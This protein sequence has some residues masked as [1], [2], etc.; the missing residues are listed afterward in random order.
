MLQF[1]SQLDDKESLLRLTGGFWSDT[2]QGQELLGTAL[3]ARASLTKQTFE[4]LQEAIDCRSRLDIPLYRKEYWRAVVLKKSV[5]E[6]FPNLYGENVNYGEGAV[7]G[8]RSASL[9]FVYP[10][11]A[12]LDDCR[13]I[14]NRLTEAS[15]NLISGL[16]F[17]IDKNYKLLRLKENPFNNPGFQKQTFEDGEEEVTLWFYKPSIDREYVYQHFGYVINLWAVTSQAYK[18]LVN[19]VYDCLVDGTSSGKVLDAITSITGIPLA[20]GNETVQEIYR[21]KHHNLVITDKNFYK[22][23]AKSEV[24][25]DEGD[26]LTIDQPL[27]DGLEYYEFNRGQTP[28]S[29]EGV[30]LLKEMLPGNY[31]G[32]IGFKNENLAT[33]VTSDLNGKTVI[34]FPLGGHPF[35]VE[36]FWNEVH[37]RGT[38]SGSTLA[39]LLDSRAV[40]TGEPTATNLPTEI[41]PMRFLVENIFRYGAFVVKIKASAVDQSAVGLDKISYVKR[42]LPPHSVMILI[43][44]AS[45]VASEIVTEADSGSPDSFRCANT[46]SEDLENTSLQSVTGLRLV[47]G[48]IL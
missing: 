37:R 3:L 43:I 20:K 48:T 25:V 34:T 5:V 11:D 24:L 47:K 2:Y 15:I 9:P 38:A 1:P 30:S 28:P 40:K 42:L 17:I 6:D 7:Y 32:E 21:D 4:R 27:S 23:A 22:L 46:L 36:A 45:E 10:V 13:L 31:M 19:N 26:K 33:T 29:I 8:K 12:E 39:N 44:T 16:D 35:D 18:D 41:N 14:S